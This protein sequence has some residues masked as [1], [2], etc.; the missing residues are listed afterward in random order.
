M[1]DSGLIEATVQEIL[2]ANPKAVMQYKNGE[3]KISGFFVGQVMKKLK[4]KADPSLV[5]KAV[6]EALDKA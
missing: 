4:G 2:T 6:A 1:E 5:N 3:T